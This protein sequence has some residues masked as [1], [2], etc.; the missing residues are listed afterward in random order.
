MI[1][2]RQS[3]EQPQDR[4]A[5]SFDRS[6][7]RPRSLFPTEVSYLDGTVGDNGFRQGG[8]VTDICLPFSPFLVDEHWILWLVCWHD[9]ITRPLNE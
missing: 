8:Q 7:G 2:E 4:L 1:T 3:L 9:T 5:I 6:K